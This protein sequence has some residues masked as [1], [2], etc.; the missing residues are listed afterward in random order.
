MAAISETA[1]FPSPPT[2][3]EAQCYYYGLPSQPKLVARLSTNIWAVPPEGYLPRK[4]CSPIGRHPLQ[5][6]WEDVVA[7]AMITYLES[8]EVKWSSLDCVRMGNAGES[9]HPAIIWIGVI[10]GSLAHEKGVEV[11]VHCKSILVASDISDVHVEIRESEV[12]RTSKLYKPARFLEPTA[13]AREPFSTALGLPISA[14]ATPSIQGTGGFFISDPRYHGKIYLVTTRHV[15]LPSDQN[16]NI[17]FQYGNSSHARKNI[18]LFS[19]IGLEKQISTIESESTHN[20]MDIE[21]LRRQLIGPERRYEDNAQVEALLLLQLKFAEKADVALKEFLADVKT[22]WVKQEDRILGHVVL[23][24]PIGLSAGEKGFTEDWVVIEIDKSSIDATNFIGNAID[25]GTISVPK[26]HDWMHTVHPGVKPSSF[27]FPLDR[28][29]KFQGT[30]PDEEMW[31]P[32]PKALDH[33]HEPRIMVIKRGYGSGITAG[34][35]NTICSFTKNYMGLSKEVSMEVV[36]LPRDSKSGAFSESGDSG[37][38]VSDSDGRVAGMITG[39]ARNSEGFDCTYFT[40]I[41]FLLERMAQ[42]GLQANLL[43]PQID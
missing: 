6:V 1:P 25:L 33:D 26:F 39:G 8:K 11:A 12:I 21:H 23:S 15:A 42:H 32:N 9:F 18:L 20:R 13:N 28:L 34:C 3:S 14:E 35:L 19:E 5:N 41:N 36:V 4:E 17:F 38:A 24:P 2:V 27:E 37:A 30:I 31:K 40:S 22:D 16:S 7:P 43:S 29:L 10:P